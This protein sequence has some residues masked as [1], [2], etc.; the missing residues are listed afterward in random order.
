MQL[1]T[2]NQ[3]QSKMLL[4]KTLEET[5]EYQARVQDEEFREIMNANLQDR[6]RKGYTMTNLHIEATFAD[7]T[8]RF[9]KTLPPPLKY[10]RG[11]AVRS[12]QNNLKF[13]EGAQVRLTNRENG[14]DFTMDVED[15]GINGF[16]LRSNDFQISKNF[17][18]SVNFPRD[19]WELNV[20]NQ[21]IT[22]KLM[23]AAIGIL[24]SDPAK[25]AFFQ[26][27]FDG[28]F[29]N[30]YPGT[31]AMNV[32]SGD[33]KSQAEAIR[34]ALSCR[35]FHLIQGPPGTGKT[36][37]VAKIVSMLLD[38]GKNVFVT[39]PTH[40]SINN[41][42][43]AV[44]AIVRDKSKV[45]KVGEKY[46]ADELSGNCNITLVRQLKSFDYESD[47]RLSKSGIVVGATPYSLCY[48][49]SKKLEGW[50]FDFAIFDEAAQLSVP[51][52]LPAMLASRKAVFVGDHQQLDPI[53]PPKGD[54][55]N[56]FGCSVFRKLTDLYPGDITLLD[57]SYRLNQD[58][59]RI[60]NEL[61]YN[62]R[63]SSLRATERPFTAFNC[64]R[65]SHTL[66]GPT[67]EVLV[68]H[69]EFDSL[70]RS[71]FEAGM[72][73]DI[74]YDLMNNNVPLHEI[75][76]ITPYRAQVREVKRM[77]VERNGMAEET[78]EGMFIDTVERMQG[79]EKAYIIYSLS[80]A[81]P[82]EA[83]DR[84]EFFY[85]PNRLNVAITRAYTK[86]IVIANDNIFRCCE[87]IL[88]EG[89]P[90]RLKAHA[91]TFLKFKELAT[92]IEITPPEEE[93]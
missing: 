67:N 15:D 44:S 58:L 79:Q 11:I 33:N 31:E 80:N 40:T 25:A 7:G 30:G 84:L 93:W 72:T 41:C 9:C 81:N 10:V 18:G 75:G 87:E 36:H 57:T 29:Q 82:R 5:V 3:Q 77:L 14:A 62:N 55:R 13:R 16:T 65:S 83:D 26:S 56:Y 74:V 39:G 69:H 20:L 64:V 86:T 45:V 38:E 54:S 32:P 34:K 73:A 24:H 49:A 60:P 47:D 78:V 22:R 90:A 76:I 50:Q 61:F 66:S 4:L 28:N 2:Q 21:E 6:V 23:M 19:G 52:A 70:G 12:M 1:K 53:I 92:K 63:L 48:P 89:A 43:N 88:Q 85:S 46:Q 71:P 42:L 8:P 91:G 27:L 68:L 35:Y 51:L 37:T 59:I 17:M